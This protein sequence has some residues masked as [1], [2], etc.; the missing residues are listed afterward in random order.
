MDYD[1]GAVI[2][3]PAGVPAFE[4]ETRFLLVFR[5][6]TKPFIFLQSMN[7]PSLCFTMIPVQM[8]DVAYR[9]HLSESDRNLLGW[10]GDRSRD[11]GADVLCL[12]MVCADEGN[13][14]TVNLLGPVVI[15]Q[16]RKK[17]I[18]AVREDGLYSAQQRLFPAERGDETCL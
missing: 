18:Q 5:E 17:G 11:P 12:G 3:F 16:R 9:L 6:E 7:T 8:V 10:T 2:E 1:D 15:D 13:P 4:S 14:P